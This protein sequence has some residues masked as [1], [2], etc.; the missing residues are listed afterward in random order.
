M[1]AAEK[2]APVERELFTLLSGLQAPL[3]RLTPVEDSLED[4]FLRATGE[5]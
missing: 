5:G 4:I 3:L 1:L 2:D